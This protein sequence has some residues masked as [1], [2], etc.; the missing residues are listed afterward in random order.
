MFKDVIYVATFKV[1]LSCQLHF[2]VDGGMLR[3]CLLSKKFIF[4]YAVWSLSSRLKCCWCQLWLF[5]ILLWAKLN[6]VFYK[7]KK[8]VL[9]SISSEDWITCTSSNDYVLFMMTIR[10]FQLGTSQTNTNFRGILKEYWEFREFWKGL[11]SGEILIKMVKFPLKL[12][13]SPYFLRNST[14]S[15]RSLDTYNQNTEQFSFDHRHRII[16]NNFNH[17][18]WFSDLLLLVCGQIIRRAAFSWTNLKFVAK[19]F[20]IK[21]K[22]AILILVRHKRKIRHFN[23]RSGSSREI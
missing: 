19:T 7:Q 18:K 5:L 20:V 4:H 11:I 23:T 10:F 1:Q 9:D 14:I 8:T 16:V 22:Y 3:L 13:K 6:N 15:L 21:E 2:D 17:A 12:R